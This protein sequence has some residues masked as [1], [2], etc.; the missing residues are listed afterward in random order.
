MRFFDVSL[1]WLLEILADL[2]EVSSLVEYLC[3]Q[4]LESTLLWLSLAHELL[5][6]MMKSLKY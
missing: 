3:V 4:L 6:V 2:A 1:E 5:D